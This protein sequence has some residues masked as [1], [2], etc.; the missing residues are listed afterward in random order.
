MSIEPGAI[1]GPYEVLQHLGSGGMGEVYLARDSRLDREV[2]LKVLPPGIDG[3]STDARNNLVR[4][5]KAASKLNH[6]NVAHVY[7]LGPYGDT[8]YIAMEYVDGGTLATRMTGGPLPV[9]S[10]VDIAVQIADALDAA[11]A[12]GIVHRDLKPGNVMLS[13]RGEPKLVDFGLAKLAVTPRDAPTQTVTAVGEI[14]GTVSYMSPEQA[15]GT[16]VDHRSDIFAFGVVL[17]EMCTGRRPFEGAS[18]TEIL[19]RILH[20]H[21]EPIARLNYE[22]PPELDRIVRKCLAKS[23]NE[24]YQS[25]RELLLDLRSLQ[26]DLHGANSNTGVVSSPIVPVKR[27]WRRPA[28]LLYVSWIAVA[29]VLGLGLASWYKGNSGGTSIAVMPFVNETGTSELDFAVDGLTESIINNLSKIGEMRVLSR[30][31][32]YRFKGRERDVQAV[33]KGLKVKNILLGRVSRRGDELVINTELI[34]VATNDQLW[35]RQFTAR[36]P[37]ILSVQEEIAQETA[38]NLHLRLSG[39][40]RRGLTRRYTENTEAYQLYLKGRFYWNKRNGPA[41]KKAV[42]YFEQAIALDRNY[43]L[44]YAGL[45]DSYGQLSG[46][47]PPREVMPKAKAAA[48]R[49]LELDET[50]AEAHASLAF[51][52]LHYDWDALETEREC[53]RALQLNPNY[54]T[55]RSIYARFLNAVGRFD[56]AVEQIQRAQELDPL[57][58]GVSTGFGLSYY[59]TGR[60]D[61]AIAQYRKVLDMDSTFYVA[62]TN[63]AAA[64]V[65]KKEYVQAASEFEKALQ[66]EEDVSTMCE[67]GQIYAVMGR[68]ED[69]LR[70]LDQVM[71][72]SK[73]RYINAPPV[74]WIHAGLGD[75]NAAFEWLERGYAERAWP[76]VFLKVEPK[77]KS[78]RADSRFEDLIKRV[79][80]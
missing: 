60:Y 2:A 6:P 46:V 61:E 73:K 41:F 28:A 56:E 43:A 1:V 14:R 66:V 72:R 42:E 8:L 49:A 7:E 63:L 11:H 32:V 65:Q 3:N 38:E 21:P 79:G 26:R 71:A 62:R 30:A 16:V 54:A 25:A 59:F 55:A 34:D 51:V 39:E 4:E 78:L 36:L 74:A 67:L 52:K 70:M 13:S 31:A 5:A 45:S 80:L 27:A 57:S 17:Y 23:P 33:A 24:R 64:L 12:K 68:R 9:S 40:E 50:L 47:I 77:Y 29:C 20:A 22:S 15:M 19:S 35:G 44:A 18:V 53:K 37:G 76:M 58:L 48:V 75:R 10:I 69:A